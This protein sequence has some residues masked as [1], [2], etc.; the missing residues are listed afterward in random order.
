MMSASEAIPSE[1]VMS[2]PSGFSWIEKP[3]LAAMS[4]PE[5]A[6]DLVWLRDQGIQIIIS[7]TE[8]PSPRRWV[9]DAGLFSVHVPIEDFQAPSL[10]QIEAVLSTVEKAQTRKMGVAIHCRAGLGRTGTILACYFVRQGM[11]ASTAIAKVRQLRPGSV[12][13]PTQEEAVQEFAR[14]RRQQR[15]KD[16]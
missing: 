13:T 3:L 8:E 9:N 14:H 4:R 1:V 15:A 7:L 10:E 12:E 5:D 6:G 11:G 16:E 2:E